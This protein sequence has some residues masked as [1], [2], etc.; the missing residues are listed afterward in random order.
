MEQTAEIKSVINRITRFRHELHQH[1]E[2]AHKE[3]NTAKRILKF[4]ENTQADKIQKEVGGNG[5]IFTYKGSQKGKNLLFRA[6]LDALPIQE[7]NT[8]DYR[9]KTDQ[10][11]HKCGHDGH[12]AIL[13]G[14]GLLLKERNF[15]GEVHLLFQPAEETGEGAQ[16]MLD[17]PKMKSIKVDHAYALHNLPGF[18]KN[19]I[20]FKTGIFAAASKGLIVKLTGKPTHASHP[21]D[22]INPILAGS[23]I[24][25]LFNEIPNMFTQ[26]EEVAQ[27]TPVGINMGQKAFGTSASE[28][29][30]YATVRA[31]D[32]AGMQRIS[33]QLEDHILQISRM[34]GLKV[35]INWTEEFKA[36]ENDGNSV[37]IVEKSIS[38]LKL[39]R[40]T[41]SH[42]FP[43]SEDFGQFSQQFPL[44]LFGLGSGEK[45]AQ[46]HQE[47]Y[48]FPDDILETGVSMFQQ[49]ITEANRSQ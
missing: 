11:S 25:Q 42:P 18:P 20:V 14:L 30:L 4:L 39:R 23:R 48:D 9:S 28:G 21:R 22:G 33:D 29:E 41:V 43:W 13:C 15:K 45:Q 19:Q 34:Y 40:Q 17:D 1:P 5:I 26:L 2:L 10:V 47:D 46:L 16:K 37:E 3:R 24:I 31:Y 38:Q 7:Q 32:N 6:E 27:I 44:C 35:S 36:V 49:I 8:M 12:M